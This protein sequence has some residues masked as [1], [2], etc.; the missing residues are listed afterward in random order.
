MKPGNKYI[1]IISLTAS[2]ALGLLLFLANTE[3][4]MEVV[5]TNK[6][7]KSIARIDL[8]TAK[9]GNKIRIHG[10]DKDTEVVVKLQTDG[11]DTLSTLIRFADDKVM[12]GEKVPIEPGIK[13][14]QSVMEEK[15]ISEH[16]LAVNTDK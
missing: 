7:G 4:N 5:I 12:Q 14:I 1:L 16:A 6:S 3:P 15:I 8:T 9:G 10:V 13:I 2:L 11:N